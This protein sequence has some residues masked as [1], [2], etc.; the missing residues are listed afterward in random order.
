SR[1][2]SLR[3]SRRAFWDSVANAS[4]ICDCAATC[5]AC[6]S[7]TRR[8]ASASSAASRAR[9]ATSRC[10]AASA[11]A[12]VTAAPNRNASARDTGIVYGVGCVF[13]SVG[14]NGDRGGHTEKR[15]TATPVPISTETVENTPDP[16]RYH[17]QTILPEFGVEGQ[18]RLRAGRVLIVG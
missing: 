4:F 10:R 9:S 13:H 8:R 7:S 3:V 14:E 16:F 5:A 17:R 15:L 2:K 6:S 1:R 11:T 12:A 18:Q